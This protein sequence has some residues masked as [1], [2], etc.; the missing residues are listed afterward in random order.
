MRNRF[1][2]RLP[3]LL[4]IGGLILLTIS[5][6]GSAPPAPDSFLSTL[7]KDT[8]ITLKETPNG[9]RITLQSPGTHKVVAT[10][11]D[12]V[13]IIDANG[14]TTTHIGK[15]AVLASSEIKLPK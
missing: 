13:T 9:Y 15:H 5:T 11:P 7:K 10:N 4:I 6:V 12:F 3:Y 2:E 1:Q 8:E 14:V